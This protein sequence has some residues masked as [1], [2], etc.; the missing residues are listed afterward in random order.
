MLQTFSGLK[1]MSLGATDGDIGHVS[2]AYFDDHEWTLRYLVVNPG[3]W[4]TGRRVLISPWAIRDVNWPAHRVD[5]TL[6][7]AQ[8]R[9]SPDMD[10]DKPVSRQYE[11]AFSDYYGYP[12]YWMGPFA[13]GPLPLPKED[14]V[15][16]DLTHEAARRE[17]EKGDPNLRSANEVDHY[18]IE[19]VDGAIGHVDDFIFDDTTWALRYSVVDTRNWLPGRHVLI[20]TDWV[21]RVS[22]EER[23][24]YV[25]LTRDEV[26]DSP[27]YEAGAF[28]QAEEDTLQRYYG[29]SL[30]RLRRK[31]WKNNDWTLP[32]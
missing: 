11:T 20:A 21:N 29:R 4:L 30:G 13:W 18:H 22:W 7:R 27:E 28:T 3:S 9:H 5:V 1:R 14:G 8:V 12:Y 17:P 6:S 15:T 32:I 26:R 19:A 16:A 23:R 31:G 25:A 10:A 24:A 2:D